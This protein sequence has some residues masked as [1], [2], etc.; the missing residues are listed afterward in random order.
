MME[1]YHGY[2]R[3]H[4]FIFFFLVCILKIDGSKGN[5]AHARDCSIDRAH[6]TEDL[7]FS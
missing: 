4:G 3:Y 1:T 6:N 7:Y 5:I 2:H